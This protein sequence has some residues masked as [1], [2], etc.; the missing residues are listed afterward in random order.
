MRRVTFLMLILTLV[1]CSCFG[2]ACA[3]DMPED[4]THTGGT[5]TCL[6]KAVCELCGEEYGELA[7]HVYGD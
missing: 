4:C 7:D 6:N 3:T 5:A 1:A 2:I